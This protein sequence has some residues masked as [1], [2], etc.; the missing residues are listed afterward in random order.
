M[1]TITNLIVFTFPSD[2]VEV[3]SF[4]TTKKA[5]AYFDKI[6]EVKKY[7]VNDL[8]SNTSNDNL[9]SIGR[10]IHEQLIEVRIEKQVIN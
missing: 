10:D 8:E 1:R 9:Y 4:S 7:E 6:R 3:K 5:I 2:R